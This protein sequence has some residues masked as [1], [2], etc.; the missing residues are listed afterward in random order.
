MNAGWQISFSGKEKSR[1]FTITEVIVTVIV[2]SI[3]LVAAFQWYSLIEYQRISLLRRAVASEI[4]YINLRKFPVRPTS[5]TTCSNS[6]DGIDLTSY[7]N[8]TPETVSSYPAASA[9]VGAAT[10]TSTSPGITGVT[11]TVKGFPVDGCSGTNFASKTFKVESTV[12]YNGGKVTRVA[13]V[14]TAAPPKVDFLVVAGGGGGGSD[15]G[16]G[17]GGGGVISKTNTE[18]DLYTPLTITVGAGGA[19]APAGVGQVRGTNGGNSVLG[20]NVA[21]GGGG[22]ASNHDRSDNR[23]GDG[24]SG[25]GASGGAVAPNGGSGGGGGYGGGA[26]GKGTAGQG[27]DG[28]FG[29]YAWYPGGGGGAGGAG[30]TNPANGGPGVASTILGT[31]YYF[32]GGGGGSGYSGCGGNGGIGGGGGGAVCATSGGGSALNSGSP[33]GGGGGNSQ[34]N[35]PGG[36]AGA[37]TGG[38][39]GGGS[40]YS[41]NNKGGNGGSGVVI[42]KIPN[43]YKISFSSGVTFTL[44]T[45]TTGFNIYTVTAA[46]STDTATIRVV[47]GT[48]N[49]E[50]L[51]VAGG[52]GGG[53]DMGG[54][55]GGGGVI[56]QASTPVE[57]N[58]PLS[59]TVGA[60][61]AGAPAGG[62]NGQNTGHNFNI[63][64]ANGGN[65]RFDSFIAIGGGGGGSSYWW[66]SPA[67]MDG[68]GFAGGSGGGA[69]GY[70]NATGRAGAGTAGQGNSG[71]GAGGSYYSGGGGGAGGVGS[72]GPSQANG[73]PGVQYPS[74]SPHYFGGG[75]GGAAYSL[76]SG[77]NG[78]IGGGGGGAVGT[79]S[80]GAGINNGS[81]GG[82]GCSN[83]WANTPGGNAGANTGGG[84]G[85]GAH[86]NS[87]NKGGNGGSGIII[88]KIPDTNSATFSSGVTQT[89]STETAGFKIYTITAAGAND[90]VTFSGSGSSSGSTT[91]A[92]PTDPLYSSVVAL[93]KFDGSD[94]ATTLTDDSPLKKDWSSTAGATISSAQKKFGAGS[95]SFGASTGYA[96]PQAGQQTNFIF[97]SSQNFTIEAWIYPTSPMQ[98][99]I[100]DSRWSNYN[101]YS[102]Y[103]SGTGQLGWATEAAGTGS[104]ASAA[105][106]VVANQWQHVAVSRA[107]GTIRL[108]VNGTQVASRA[109]TGNYDGVP[110]TRPLLGVDANVTTFAP[111]KY[112]GYID[113]LRI[114]RAARYTSNFTAPTEDF[115]TTAS[116]GGSTSSPTSISYD[117]D[118]VNVR[119][120]S[121]GTCSLNTTATG[122]I[123]V[124]IFHTYGAGNTLTVTGTV[125]GTNM[126]TLGGPIAAH[127][128][129]PSVFGTVL[130]LANVSAGAKTIN[131]NLA[132]SGTSGVWF[133]CIAYKGVS[134]FGTVSSGSNITS[135]NVPARTSPF[136]WVGSTMVGRN[137]STYSLATPGSTQRV[138]VLYDSANGYGDNFQLQM[139]DVSNASAHTWTMT[140]LYGTSMF[141]VPLN[142]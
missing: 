95:L 79:T 129:G 56:Y 11:Q 132:N 107:S 76:A 104:F 125:N 119:S 105:G 25:G 84:G 96:G 131:I 30:S 40:H 5:L 92:T 34:T 12:T 116:S 48:I 29:I 124:L 93:L 94:G 128:Y 97:G 26:A 85:G 138:H 50:L 87:N 63:P 71:G 7:N 8:F 109:D 42:I 57:L 68:F 70:A 43:K 58:A 72:S 2:L 89:V 41:A 127:P 74:L 86:Y 78:G 115:P 51:V 141:A 122:G 114:T 14:S 20:T 100:M 137:Y 15:M 38:G 81:P 135:L 54:G 123:I 75:G 108:F 16:G 121:S 31:T 106:V 130:G 101:Y 111:G 62:T 110:S 4:A 9:L 17:G 142:L 39:G 18:L 55:G 136:V 59:L 3:F 103:I 140:N 113:S 32:A 10:T 45:A 102:F 46:S 47:S 98:G 6:P 49:A 44:N 134:S 112:N 61:G 91:P 19:G 24:G 80:G 23:A 33:G 66:G 83:C 53:M 73:G 99:Y 139:G 36:N 27:Y 90:T 77:G 28:S 118:A 1:G 120:T 133:H 88:I 117:T 69:S 52:G 13:F 82:G 126:N 65:S 21:I 37:N 22:G 67:P 35:T 60:G 64:P